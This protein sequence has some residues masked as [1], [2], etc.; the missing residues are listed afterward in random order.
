[1]TTSVYTVTAGQSLT[2]AQSTMDDARIRHIPVVADNDRLVGLITHRDLLRAKLS[3]LA[4]LHES[5]REDYEFAIPVSAI[6]REI[7]WTV[8]PD[9][10]AVVAARIMSENRFGCLPVVRGDRLVGILT[11]ADLLR[12][13]T[14]SLELSSPPPLPT[15]EEV[16]TGAPRMVGQRQTLG[17]ARALMASAHVRHMPIVDDAGGPVGIISDRDLRLADALCGGREA[18]DAMSVQ[19]LGSEP[20]FSVPKTAL[21]GPVLLDM[22]AHKRGSALVVH[23]GRLVGILTTTDACRLFGERIDGLAAEGPL[24]ES[25]GIWAR[26]E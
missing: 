14:D 11:E 10:K 17:E 24:Q 12:L 6:M 23:D 26:A 19:L 13:V 21:L 4:P 5:L 18:A 22:A 7:V 3:E 20:P 16:M 8:S 25:G 15:V 1:M 2:L 9:S